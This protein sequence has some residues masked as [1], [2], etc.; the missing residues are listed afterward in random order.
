MNGLVFNVQKF[1]I[2]DGPGIRTTVFFQGCNMRCKWCANPESF[3]LHPTHPSSEAKE[4]TI[5]ALVSELKKDKVFYDGSGGG[6]TLSGGEPLLQPDFACAL[7]DAL[8]I[9]K[10]NVC[11]ETAAH[12]HQDVF[13]KVA[14]KCEIVC[15][16]L[17]HHD[18]NAH[19][20]G[21]NVGMELILSNIRALIECGVHTIIRIP[22]I[23]GYNDSAEDFE[24]FALLLSSL[25]AQDIQLLPFH[26]MGS[27]KYQKLGLEYEFGETKSFQD[28]DVEPFAKSLRKSG[29]NVQ[30][31]G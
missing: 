8:L 14:M 19:R 1:S 13:L 4:Y 20:I 6:V 3:E 29:F 7:C 5:D 30:I 11:L 24:K 12:V 18:D 2:H 25:K 26:R 23:P 10:I 21:T 22:V 16:D 27:N 9:E 15:I 31:G 28:K 17:K